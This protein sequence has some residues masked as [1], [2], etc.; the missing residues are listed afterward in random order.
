MGICQS[1]RASRAKQNPVTEPIFSESNNNYIIAEIYIKNEDINKGIQILS[2][3]ENFQR[4]HYNK[5]EKEHMNE[6]EIKKCEI[7]LNDKLIQFTYFYQF[8]NKGKYIIKYSFYN[9][10]SKTN[11]IFFECSSLIN[12]D[13]SNFNT[14]NVTDMR[15]MFN[16]C[17]S[18]IFKFIKF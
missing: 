13:L 2:S 9:Y 18:L 1:E 8:T 15:F 3:Y 4:R 14:Q 16:K 6:E 10:L 17:S 7:R 11:Y 12:I 5:I